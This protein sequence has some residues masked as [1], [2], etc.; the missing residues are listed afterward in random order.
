MDYEYHKELV[1][2]AREIYKQDREILP[3]PLIKALREATGCGLVS[4]KRAVDELGMY[5]VTHPRPAEL[6]VAKLED[7]SER[8]MEALEE[9]LDKATQGLRPHELTDTAVKAR[10]AIEFAKSTMGR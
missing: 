5:R 6:Q 7:A 4:A 3:I 10:A 2:K 9:L 1:E 8:L